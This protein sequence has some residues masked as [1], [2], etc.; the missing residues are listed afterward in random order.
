MTPARCFARLT[1]FAS[2]AGT[3][4]AAGALGL[5]ALDAGADP[6]HLGTEML[7]H[8]DLTTHQAVVF[9]VSAAK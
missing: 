6:V 5:A 1:R 8:I 9:V 2:I 7:E 3:A 4:L